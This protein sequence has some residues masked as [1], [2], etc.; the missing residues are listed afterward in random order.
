MTLPDSWFTMADFVFVSHGSLWTCTPASD[1]LREYLQQN[2]EDDAQW[3]GG[4]LIVE[5]RYAGPLAQQLANDG[6]LVE[7]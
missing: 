3:F 1:E 4:A 2:T 6:F 7:A 5:A